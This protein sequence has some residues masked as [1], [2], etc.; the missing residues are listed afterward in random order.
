MDIKRFR[1]S[2]PLLYSD[3]LTT[4]Q[5]LDE[6]LTTTNLHF[7]FH[8]IHHFN[9]AL[10]NNVPLLKKTRLQAVAGGGFLWLADNAYRHQELFGG[11]ERV[12]KLGAR[13]R[14]RVGAYAVVA[15]ATDAQPTTS[16]KVSFDLID[17]WRRNW[18]F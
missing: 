15:D 9:G 5:L 14:L 13:R 12:F 1:E 8:H 7:E 16:F 18:S 4:F 6:E 17:I 10:I 3:P 11:V 2:D